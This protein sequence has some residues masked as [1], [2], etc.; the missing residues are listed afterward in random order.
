[1][2]TINVLLFWLGKKWDGKGGIVSECQTKVFMRGC[3]LSFVMWS[4]CMTWLNSSLPT[5]DPL[6][7]RGNLPSIVTEA[8]EPPQLNPMLATNCEHEEF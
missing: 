1:M 3:D 7:T 4:I 5:T 8:Q 2:L 6:Q